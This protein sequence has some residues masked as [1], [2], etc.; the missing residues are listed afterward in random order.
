MEPFLSCRNQA[1]S[2]ILEATTHTDARR[3]I[4][5]AAA[6]AAIAAAGARTGVGAARRAV[7]IGT[8]LG[9]RFRFAL[10]L[11]PVLDAVAIDIGARGALNFSPVA[12]TRGKGTRRLVKRTTCGIVETIATRSIRTG[13]ITCGTIAARATVT[14]VLTVATRRTIA[15]STRCAVGTRSAIT[16]RAMIALAATEA[17]L[18][19]KAAGA[20]VAAITTA[21]TTITR[22]RTAA[23]TALRRCVGS[24]PGKVCTSIRLPV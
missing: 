5:W 11:F 20:A 2:L 22:S 8:R 9:T 3:A 24:N 17:A 19:A 12:F 1:C 16:T 4:A 18:F 23:P 21:R 15:I 14:V 6:V 10:A 7:T 13:T